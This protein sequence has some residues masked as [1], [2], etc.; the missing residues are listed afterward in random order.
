LQEDQAV[1]TALILIT[2]RLDFE[3]FV[4]TSSPAH[5]EGDWDEFGACPKTLEDKL[6]LKK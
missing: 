1:I 4:T 2:R 6:R 3:A 5:L